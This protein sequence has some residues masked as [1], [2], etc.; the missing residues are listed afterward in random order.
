MIDAIITEKGEVIRSTSGT[1][2]FKAVMPRDGK[3]RLR[4]LLKREQKGVAKR[5][6]SFKW[7]IFD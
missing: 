7:I 1:F 6:R 4:I 3:H 5:V 2:N